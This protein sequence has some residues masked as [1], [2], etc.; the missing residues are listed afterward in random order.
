MKILLLGADG[1]LGWYLRAAL[2][3]LG[4]VT[5]ATRLGGPNDEGCDLADAGAVRALLQATQPELIINAAA[6]TAVDAAETDA[7]AAAALNT[8]LPGV[9]GTV[10]R[11]QG[12]AVIHYSTDYVFPGNRPDARTESDPTGPLSVYGRT[13]YLGEQALAESGARHL[14]LRTAWVYSLR[15]R[16]FLTTMLRLAR[17]RDEL[18][19][20]ADQHGCPTSAP[21]L[22]SCTAQIA[23]S[24]MRDTAPQHGL[25]HLTAMGSTT[26]HG[27]A[28]AIVARAYGMG[29]LPRRIPVRAISTAEF[30]TPATRPHWSLLDTQRVRHDFGIALPSW[31]DDLA[32]VMAPLASGV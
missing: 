2:A 23:A 12:A 5:T 1:Q 4:T 3:P 15:G 25:Y 13:K 32:E 31:E 24:W 14:I 21:L 27:F 10:A 17:E 22:A 26:W 16:N 19:V 7:D 30:P 20:V 18:R 6:Y 28:E 11:E 29:A 9:L 8:R